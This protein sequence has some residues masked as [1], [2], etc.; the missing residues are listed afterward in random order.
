MIIK[1]CLLSF[2]MNKSERQR[3]TA[4]V[5][6]IGI[7]LGFGVIYFVCYFI[8]D[9]IS[10]TKQE[11]SIAKNKNQEVLRTISKEEV[12]KR[13]VGQHVFSCNGIFF[14]SCKPKEIYKD[15]VQM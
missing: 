14:R 9:W 13:G 2:A 12:M 3:G 11:R 6:V 15:T 10:D 4:S 5:G 7:M 8:L 1:E